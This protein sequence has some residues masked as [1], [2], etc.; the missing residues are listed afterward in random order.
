MAHL[1]NERVKE[2]YST[3]G[4]LKVLDDIIRYRAADA[5][6]VPILGYPRSDNDL[7]DYEK[8]TGRQL[9]FFVDGAANHLIAQGLEPV[10]PRQAQPTIYKLNSCIGNKKGCRNFRSI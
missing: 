9:D 10:R 2:L 7:S 3:F 8:F 4:E 1:T 6:Q 5:D